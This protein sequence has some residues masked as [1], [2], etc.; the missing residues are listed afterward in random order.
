MNKIL[1]SM[2]FS[3]IAFPAISGTTIHFSQ[4]PDGE[5]QIS[6]PWGD[7]AA[8][9]Q[10]STVWV[11]TAEEFE[12]NRVKG[13]MADQ[14]LKEF[15]ISGR[16]KAGTFIERDMPTA[17]AGNTQIASISTYVLFGESHKRN[18][19]ALLSLRVLSMYP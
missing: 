3:L 5:T 13:I 9:Q 7:Y 8:I 1:I 4:G 6:T 14:G 17:S 15:S 12:H 2:L 16:S 10:G 19:S 11:G 18:C